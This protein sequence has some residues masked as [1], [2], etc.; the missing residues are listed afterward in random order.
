MINGKKENYYGMSSGFLEPGRSPLEGLYTDSL[1]EALFIV[2]QEE[3]WQ[4]STN[5]NFLS[6]QGTV[7]KDQSL[8]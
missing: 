8:K 4:I 7:L 3:P 6:D 5:Q 1:F 2:A